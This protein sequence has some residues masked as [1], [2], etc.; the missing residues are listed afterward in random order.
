MGTLRGLLRATHFEP[1]VAVTA[2]T[3]ALAIQAG[4]GWGSLWVAVAVLCGQAS[5]GWSNDW[6]DAD[7][8]SRAGRIEKPIVAGVISVN[9]VRRAALIAL[10]LC[11]PLSLLSGWRATLVHMAAIASA[12]AYNAG[13]KARLLSPL[14][15]ALSFALLP[16]FVTLG[17]SQPHWP[18][19]ILM[20]ITAILGVGFHL[21]NTIG[22]EKADRMNSVV[23]LPQRLG[24]RASLNVAVLLF[25]VAIVALRRLGNHWA[26][27]SDLLTF[28][29]LGLALG[30]VWAGHKGRA[31]AAQRFS[32]GVVG[33]CLLL[34]V[35][36][37]PALTA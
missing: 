35:I 15:Y 28:G 22:D 32:L 11:I 14:P 30:V 16:A 19:P 25:V 36:E 5:V 2:A 4:R 24:P 12:W 33:C 34:F 10:L 8:D 21:I 23:G 31:I 1:T 27:V 18:R 26:L 37:H 20:I 6:F 7:R 9:T 3:T 13:F 17:L 29:A